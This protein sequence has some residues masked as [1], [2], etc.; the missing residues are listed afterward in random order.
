MIRRVYEYPSYHSGIGLMPPAVIHHGLG[1]ERWEERQELLSDFYRVHPE[2]FVRGRPHPPFLPRSVW[3]N[4]PRDTTTYRSL[5]K[6]ALS[7]HLEPLF[8][9]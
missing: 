1:E 2:R 3:I 4:P 6:G 7:S 9:Q 5:E 8:V